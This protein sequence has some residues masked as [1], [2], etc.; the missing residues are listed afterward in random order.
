[1]YNRQPMPGQ[2]GRMRIIPENGDP[3]FYAKVEMADNPLHEGTPLSKETLLQD[4][5]AEL[6]GLPE[7]AVP[8]D[9]LAFLGKYSQHWWWRK[10]T[11]AVTAWREVRTA[12]SEFNLQTWLN[13]STADNTTKT[14]QY[15]SAINIS[16]SGVVSLKN[17]QTVTYNSGASADVSGKY[18]LYNSDVVFV[19]AVEVGGNSDGDT[20]WNATGVK[21]VTAESYE[22]PVG[23]EELIHSPDRNAYPDG[24][25]SD[26]YKWRY[27]GVPFE[28]AVNPGK[29]IAGEYV[30]TGKYGNANPCVLTFDAVPVLLYIATNALTDPAPTTN[31]RYFPV[32]CA[33]LTTS[34]QV[35]SSTY[36]GDYEMLYF[37]MKKSEDGR[38]IYWYAAKSSGL[39]DGHAISAQLNTSGTVYRY[40]AIG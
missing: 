17:P 38:S 15:S 9:V 40:T 33:Y 4:A 11:A 8:D 24:G 29:V 32:H 23:E 16:S 20:W 37:Y 31:S 14:Y 30:G 34:Y 25:E 10:S 21:I 19:T 3:A 27:L 35:V 12:T 2:E 18:M 1:M 28:N 26:G 6:F 39:S 36:I 13:Y 22:V 7:S 5:T